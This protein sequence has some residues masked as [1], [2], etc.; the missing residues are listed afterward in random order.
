MYKVTIKGTR[1][2][3]PKDV[4]YVEPQFVEY[5]K[6][7]HINTKNRDKA[8]E[9]AEA[10]IRKWEREPYFKTEISAVQVYL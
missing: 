9:I 1:Q 4:E 5:T 7:F 8:L 3:F 6:V 10:G 2:E